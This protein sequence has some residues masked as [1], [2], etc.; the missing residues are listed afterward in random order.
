[1]VM[2]IGEISQQRSDLLQL[3]HFGAIRS[4]GAALIIEESQH[5]E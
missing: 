4:R 2:I 5:N 1:M 3:S